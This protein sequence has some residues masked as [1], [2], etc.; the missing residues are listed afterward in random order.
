MGYL[1]DVLIRNHLIDN[2][3]GGLIDNIGIICHNL[4]TLTHSNT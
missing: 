1:L 2:M 3:N 4:H